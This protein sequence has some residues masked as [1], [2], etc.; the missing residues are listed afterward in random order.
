MTLF[1]GSSFIALKTMAPVFWRVIS[2]VPSQTPLP[3]A[4]RKVNPDCST[5]EIT[6]V[7]FPPLAP[8]TPGSSARRFTVSPGVSSVLSAVREMRSSVISG[9]ISSTSEEIISLR[10]MTFP[11]SGGGAFLAASRRE[12]K[13][14]DGPVRS[15]ITSSITVGELV[16]PTCMNSRRVFQS[17]ARNTV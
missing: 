13:F 15:S 7:M 11:S 9:K 4:S 3:F 6:T 10:G 12:I 16:N 5:C 1:S 14:E 17:E 8:R 2:N